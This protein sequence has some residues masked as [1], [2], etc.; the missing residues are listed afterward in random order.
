MSKT[1]INTSVPHHKKKQ[2]LNLPKVQKQSK[3]T[4]RGSTKILQIKFPI[5]RDTESPTRMEI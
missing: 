2:T 3:R 5:Q 4:K 1:F